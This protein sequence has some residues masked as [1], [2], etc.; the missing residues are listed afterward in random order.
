MKTLTLLIALGLAA[1]SLAAEETLVAQASKKKPAKKDDKKKK[2]D[3]KKGD[4]KKEEAGKLKGP[5]AGPKLQAPR[6]DTAKEAEREALAD[7]KRDESIESLKK[8]IAGGKVS[9]NQ[10]AELLFQLA[11]LWWEKSKFVFGKEMAAYDKS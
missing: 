2:G 4:D 6:Y 10:K 9:G 8:I 5:A 7:K 1:P 3:E 11:E